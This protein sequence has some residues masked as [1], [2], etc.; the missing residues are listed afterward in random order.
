MNITFYTQ[1]NKR[2]EV[3][4]CIQH[5]SAQFEFIENH[6]LHNIKYIIHYHKG[7]IKLKLY[8]TIN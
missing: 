4:Y 3:I 8:H 6:I 2:E 7:N 5:I 1:L